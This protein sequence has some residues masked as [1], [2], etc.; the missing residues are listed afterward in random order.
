MNQST[1]DEE[2]FVQSNGPIEERTARQMI[3]KEIQRLRIE[4]KKLMDELAE[5]DTAVQN[6]FSFIQSA[7]A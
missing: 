6:L 1:R 5:K 7:G 4:N 3:D 2:L